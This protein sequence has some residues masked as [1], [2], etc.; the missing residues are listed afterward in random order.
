[1][2]N[3]NN[4]N[5]WSWVDAPDL[6]IGDKIKGREDSWVEVTS[7]LK[8]NGLIEVK[9]L[10]VEEKDTYFAGN[11]PIVVHNDLVKS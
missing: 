5:A 10:D 3:K 8:V 6:E 1:L 11:T 9:T 2:A 4:T 7:I